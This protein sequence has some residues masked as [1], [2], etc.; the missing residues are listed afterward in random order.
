M[1]K[2]P[3]L[4]F[5]IILMLTNIAYAQNKTALVIG[6]GSYRHFSPLSSP[7]NEASD[8]KNALT[9]LG[10][11]VILLLDGTQD[12]ILDAVSDFEYKLKNRL[13]SRGGLALFHYGGHGVQ[14]KRIYR[15]YQ[16]GKER[17]KKEIRGKAEDR[18][19]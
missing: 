4:T 6:N 5:L 11:D 12:S 7:K 17:C 9:R 10:F 1:R 3:I 8:M 16:K 2:T 19:L 14:V 13:R 15:Y 18:G